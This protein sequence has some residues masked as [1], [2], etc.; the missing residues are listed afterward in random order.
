MKFAY[1]ILLGEHVAAREAGYWDAA[2]FY[3][4]CPSCKDPVIK[5]ERDIEKDI[6]HFF[7]HYRAV[8]FYPRFVLERTRLGGGRA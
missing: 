7:S 8:P 2:A 6:S 3:L 4:V 5:V 1:S